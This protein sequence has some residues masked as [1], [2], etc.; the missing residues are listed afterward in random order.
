M[1][2]EKKKN[3]VM[4]CL[5]AENKEDAAVRQEAWKNCH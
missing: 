4:P 1:G 3:E 2:R 5:R